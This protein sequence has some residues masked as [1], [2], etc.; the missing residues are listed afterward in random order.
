MVAGAELFAHALEQQVQTLIEKVAFL[1][2]V[3]ANGAWMT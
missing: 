2:A 1:E 3:I